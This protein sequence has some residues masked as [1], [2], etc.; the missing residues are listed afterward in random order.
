M[1]APFPT[2]YKNTVNSDERA[3][4]AKSTDSAVTNPLSG[5]AT[6]G[7]AYLFCGSHVNGLP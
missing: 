1:V 5:M 4:G 7:F 3:N 2:Y 6:T